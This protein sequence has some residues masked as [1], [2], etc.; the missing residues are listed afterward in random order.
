MNLYIKKQNLKLQNLLQILY[1]GVAYTMWLMERSAPYQAQAY[2]VHLVSE[3]KQ[4][5]ALQHCCKHFTCRYTEKLT[6]V[7]TQYTK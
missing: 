7:H 3:T 6:E 4:S 1:M 2:S 5:F